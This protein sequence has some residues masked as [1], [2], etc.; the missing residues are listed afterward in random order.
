MAT[1][2][3]TG[4]QRGVSDL[5]TQ[6][7]TASL[8]VGLRNIG[9]AFV[10]KSARFMPTIYEHL[11]AETVN[12]LVWFINQLDDRRRHELV[13]RGGSVNADL[14][15]KKA[16]WFCNNLVI[17]VRDRNNDNTAVGIA[18]AGWDPCRQNGDISVAVAD[19]YRGGLG[20][21]LIL[22]ACGQL[23]VR[24]VRRASAVIESGNKHSIKA[25][26]GCGFAGDPNNEPFGQL[27]FFREL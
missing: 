17:I 25:F 7:V 27:T 13:S 14:I 1:L 3:M 22:A 4:P 10:G 9:R 2:T 21:W 23:T 19:G 12:E 15:K 26:R 18:F 24:R 20:R 8:C 6:L 11:D 16:R 5:W